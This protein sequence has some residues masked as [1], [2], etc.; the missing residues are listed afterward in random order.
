MILKSEIADVA[1]SSMERITSLNSGVKRIVDWG[2]IGSKSYAL[3]VSGIRRC[4]K[5]TLMR[6]MISE[7]KG[8]KCFFIN[9]DDPRL[10]GFDL[11]DFNRVNEIIEEGK[12]THLFFDEIQLVPNWERFIRLLIDLEKYH[13]VISGSN[14]SMLSNE[15]G[16]H[17]TGRHISKELFPFSFDEFRII[18]KSKEA[19]AETTIAYLNQGGF[20][21]YLKTNNHEVL[22]GILNDIIYRDISVRFGIRNHLALKQL[23]IYL[24]SNAGN[25]LTANSL[26]KVIPIAAT[27]TVMEYLGYFENAYLAF[28]VP[29][30]SYSYSKQ[31]QNPRKIYCIDTGMVTANTVSFSLDDG[32]RFENL[33]FLSLRRKTRE[34]YYYAEKGECDFVLCQNNQPLNLIQACFNLTSDNLNRELEG[35]Y[36]AMQFFN[37]NEGTI[38]TLDQND[39]FKKG[40]MQIAVLPYHNWI[41]DL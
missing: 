22:S 1:L 14:A 29:K 41:A 31:I 24:V 28:F 30:F 13:I 35:L 39:H 32:R 36:E 3:I 40:N 7:L 2:I 12:Y 10:F 5:S 33:V 8:E 9:L 34:I 6:Q 21:E 17:L 20:P 18:T 16:I 15:L 11:N 27:S 19:S 38:V 37:M 26:R 4:G 23:A 25:L